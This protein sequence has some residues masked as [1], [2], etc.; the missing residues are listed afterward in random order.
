MRDMATHPSADLFPMLSA[1]DMQELADDIKQNGLVHPIVTAVEDGIEY[2]IDGRNRL[3]A[4][5]MAGVVPEFRSFEGDIN[6]FINSVN[7]LRR[8]LTKGQKA[9]AYA[10]MFPDAYDKSFPAGNKSLSPS[11][12]VDIINL[13]FP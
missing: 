12:Q 6:A 8:E 5:E 13:I 7:N 2:L 10:V 3:A 9:M 1:D 4:C 11:D